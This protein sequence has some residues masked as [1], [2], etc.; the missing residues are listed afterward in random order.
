[1][2]SPISVALIPVSAVLLRVPCQWHVIPFLSALQISHSNE[3][4]M[5]WNWIL[6]QSASKS[7]GWTYPYKSCSLD[8]WYENKDSVRP[9]WTWL[10]SGMDFASIYI[11]ESQ[12]WLH[13]TSVFRSWFWLTNNDQ[14]TAVWK[15]LIFLQGSK[16]ATDQTCCGPKMLCFQMRWGKEIC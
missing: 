16:I 4:N 2:I 14:N 1:M 12:E 8:W 10:Y 9:Q 7:V 11:I 6:T 3:W 5:E 13:Y 15:C